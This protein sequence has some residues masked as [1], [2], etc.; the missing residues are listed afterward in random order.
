MSTEMLS[1]KRVALL[2]F[3]EAETTLLSQSLAPAEVFIR[4]F[5][6]VETLPSSPVLKQYELILVAVRSTEGTPWND[7]ATFPYAVERC[8]AVGAP[9]DLLP[10]AVQSKT[11]YRHFCGWPATSDEILFRC[12]CALHTVSCSSATLSAT[13]STVVLA[14]DDS[15]ITALLRLTLKR[16]GLHC[17]IATTGGEALALIRRVKPC[18]AVLDINMPEMDGFAILSE[19]RNSPDLA[20][21]RVLLLTGCEQESDI[22]RGFTLGAD[23]YVVKPFNPM[24]L[25]VRLR[26]LIGAS[27]PQ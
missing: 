22:V 11:S 6:A 13:S 21:T 9:R 16:N 8:I 10:F 1:G 27:S 2:G 18:A 5:S 12:I 24:E 14:D 26:R 4:S 23:D 3:D 25:M 7:P 19:M 17:E 15:S 20:G